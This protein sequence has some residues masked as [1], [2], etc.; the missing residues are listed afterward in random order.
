MGQPLSTDSIGAPT[1]WLLVFNHKAETWWSRLAAC[2]R[3]KHVRA[4]GYV[5][6]SDAYVFFD[7]QFEGMSIQ[8]ARGDGARRLMVEWCQ[9]ADVLRW[10]RRATPGHRFRCWMPLLCTTAIAHLIG[11]PFTALRPDALYRKCLQNGATV[12]NGQT[13][14]H[15]PGPAGP[16]AAAAHADCPAAANPSPPN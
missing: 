14:R 15:S 1:R 3:L 11:L 2:G 13:S 16:D 12:V 10:D 9:E 7:P 6:G 4:F 5:A 8:I